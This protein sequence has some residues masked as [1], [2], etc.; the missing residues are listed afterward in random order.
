MSASRSRRKSP[1]RAPQQIRQEILDF[2]QRSPHPVSLEELLR[3]L[4]LPAK[5][6]PLLESLVSELLLEGVIY[7]HKGGIAFR[8]PTESMPTPPPSKKKKVPSSAQGILRKHPRGFG[9][10]APQNCPDIQ[11]VFIPKQ[12]TSGAMDG[13][14]VEVSI[15]PHSI[16]SQ[17]GPEGAVLRILERTRSHLVGYVVGP[18]MVWI[19][20]LE[21][22]DGH[23]PVD[24]SSQIS[25]V[26]GDRVVCQM[27]RWPKADEDELGSVMVIRNLGSIEDASA[28]IQVAIEEHQLRSQFPE[29]VL[30][31]A[32]KYGTRVSNR[33]LEGREDLREVECFTIDPTTAKDFDDALSLV[34]TRKGH[35]QL[36]VHI[37]DVAHYVTPGSAL[38]REARRRCNSTYFPGRCIP[39]LPHELSDNLCSLKEAVNRLT[40]T[41]FMEFDGTGELLRY[42]IVR[43]VIRSAKRFSYAEALEVIEGKRRSKHSPTLDNMVELCNLLKAKRAERGSVELALSDVQVIVNDAGEPTGM[44]RHEYDITHQMVE[45][46]MLKANEIVAVH[47]TKQNKPVAYRIHAPPSTDS[48]NE[49]MLTARALGFQLKKNPAQED[50]QKLF[51]EAAKS[52]ILEQLAIAF[53][54]SMNLAFY[55]PDNIGHYGLGLDHYCHFTSPIRRYPDLVGQRALFN[56]LEAD[57]T[58][59]T[60]ACSEQERRSARA[61]DSVVKLK[62]LRMLRKHWQK[63]PHQTYSAIITRVRPHGII[64]EITDMMV[65]GFIHVRHLGHEFFHHD[66]R[67]QQFVGEHTGTTFGVGDLIQVRLMNLNLM[68]LE[69]EWNSELAA[70]RE[71]DRPDRP[72]SKPRR[73]K[74]HA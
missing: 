71:S 59:L 43:T 68:T 21:E 20:G 51:K 22:S 36:G 1:K 18:Q 63:D 58:L 7:T 3:A 17:K 42:R 49:F 35:Y 54:K 24:A 72:P 32:M 50:L 15:V 10:V 4:R 40:V 74:R 34:K 39:M 45:E 53:V 13:D 6:G 62:K 46:F 52:P 47:L 67:A 55:S 48:L 33:D 14:L 28:D 44:E 41:V 29:D 30:D 19:R 61:E 12:A 38:D 56:L 73:S 31:E 8:Q 2:L 70:A 37:A 66:A 23:I 65:E 69:T 60:E 25:C 57:L 64:F 9:F 16:N 26:E 11:E 27:I 5:D